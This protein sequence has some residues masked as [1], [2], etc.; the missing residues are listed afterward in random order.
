MLSPVRL[1]VCQ[2]S[3]GYHTKSVDRIMKFLSYGS[4]IPLALVGKVSIRNSKWFP[5]SCGVK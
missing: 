4:P 3:V 2:T 5:P 1:S